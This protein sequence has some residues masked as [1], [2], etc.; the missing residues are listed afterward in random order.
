VDVLGLEAV[1]TAHRQL[2]LVDRTQQDRIELHRADLGR[3]FFLA[4]QVDEH[5]QLVLEDAPARRIASSGIDRAVGLD[6]DDQLVEVGAL[7]DARASTE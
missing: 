1:R 6:V 2:E 4:L 7:F 5:R 3:R